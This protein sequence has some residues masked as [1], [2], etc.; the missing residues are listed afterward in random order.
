[1][2]MNDVAG[3]R[4]ARI[5]GRFHVRTGPHSSLRIGSCRFRSHRSDFS[6]SAIAGKVDAVGIMR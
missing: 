2:Q 6:L 5:L 4:N 3:E 1:M